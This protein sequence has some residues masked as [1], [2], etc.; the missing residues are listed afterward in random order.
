M[1]WI[2]STSGSEPR[3]PSQPRVSENTS[4][5]EETCFVPRSEIPSNSSPDQLL[6]AFV[7]L[8]ADINSSP[9]IHDNNALENLVNKDVGFSNIHTNLIGNGSSFTVRAWRLEAPDQSLVFKS[10]LPSDYKFTDKDERRRLEDVILELRTLSH[11]ALTNQDNIVKL[12]GLGWETDSFEKGRKWPVLILEY[13]DGGTLQDFLRNNQVAPRGK[14]KIC[15]DI[16]YGLAALH[17]V[18]V[19][20]GDV[21]PENILMFSHLS[22]NTE[23]TWIAKLSDFGGAALEVSSK[24][25][26][27]LRTGTQ[28]WNAPEWK[29]PMRPADMMKQDIYS[30]GLVAFSI[31]INGV[32]PFS[33]Q[34]GIFSFPTDCVDVSRRNAYIQSLKQ[35]DSHVL[36]KLTDAGHSDKI[37]GIDG[38]L[39][40]LILNCT[41]QFASSLRSLED[42]IR[43]LA[44][45]TGR[46]SSQVALKGWQRHP[47]SLHDELA[48]HSITVSSRCPKISIDKW[49]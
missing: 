37:N 29:T 20:H 48:S 21:K 9:S 36:K 2:E 26:D 34:A 8:A 11:P 24:G 39:L 28:P 14:L 19:I 49:R 25:L 27:I 33:S 42:A 10:V 46:V 6:A 40:E 43:I 17:D 30:F 35:K 13:A 32:D 38:Y 15:Q 7:A 18:G 31:A 12:L 47:K 22:N 5:P 41:I 16:A 1:S 23:R 4:G 45:E 3:P 44:D